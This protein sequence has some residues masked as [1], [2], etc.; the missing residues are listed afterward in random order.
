MTEQRDERDRME[1]RAETTGQRRTLIFTALCEENPAA[2]IC[3]EQ[4]MRYRYNN[5]DATFRPE[6]STG[7]AFDP[8]KRYTD[9][10]I[11]T[12]GLPHTYRTAAPSIRVPAQF[13]RQRQISSPPPPSRA[14]MKTTFDVW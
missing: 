4:W 13:R 9:T 14:R 1:A 2:A 5:N 6:W 7:W 10:P 3:S 12:Q 8:D 11:I